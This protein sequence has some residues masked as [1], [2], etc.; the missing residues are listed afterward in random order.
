MIA[1]SKNSRRVS[2]LLTG[3]VSSAAQITPAPR[4]SDPIEVSPKCNPRNGVQLAGTWR[5]ELAGEPIE[6]LVPVRA[7]H[8]HFIWRKEF[9]GKPEAR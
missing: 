3:S 8:N 7:R 1:S 4:E 2:H 6:M 9:E 5:D